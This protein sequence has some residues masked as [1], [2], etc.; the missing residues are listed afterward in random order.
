MEELKE[1]VASLES[2]LALEKIEREQM[3]DVARVREFWGKELELIRKWERDGEAAHERLDREM[4]ALRRKVEEVCAEVFPGELF[5][6]AI[7]AHVGITGQTADLVE[8]G[9]VS[10]RLAA[11][12]RERERLVGEVK[13]LREAKEAAES[14]SVELL[15]ERETELKV[16]VFTSAQTYKHI[17]C[18]IWGIH[19]VNVYTC[20]KTADA[21]LML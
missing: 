14:R 11:L 21:I 3:K 15:E 4:E 5:G 6:G 17:L 9:A 16:I 2:Q 10:P 18:W 13:V 19:E 20:T 7:G 12:E 8:L 1:K